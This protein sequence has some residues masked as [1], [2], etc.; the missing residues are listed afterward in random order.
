MESS[1]GEN[2]KKQITHSGIILEATNVC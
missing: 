2:A 1:N